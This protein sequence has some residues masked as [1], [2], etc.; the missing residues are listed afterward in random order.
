MI[1]NIIFD[2]GKVLIEFDPEYYLDKEKVFDKNDRDLLLKDIFYSPYWLQ[3]DEGS[4]DET[5]MFEKIKD[6]IPERL[7]GVSEALL[8]HWHD[9]L[10]PIEGMDDLVMTLKEKGYGIYL[11]SNA[12]VQQ[13][14]YWPRYKSSKNFDGV[15][16]SAFER[17]IKPDP[18]I[19]HILL[20][21]Y[22]LKAEECIFIDDRQI[23]VDTADNIGMKGHLFIDTEELKIFFE[24]EGIL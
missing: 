4:L 17:C 6:I 23:N 24:K 3:M 15:V 14:E 2:M 18:A 20:D 16:V 22:H 5:E 8:F 7:H 11:L 1:K 21:R 9:P 19:Y 12:S 13:K 10:I